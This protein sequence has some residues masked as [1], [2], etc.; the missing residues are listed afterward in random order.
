MQCS[1]HCVQLGFDGVGRRK[2]TA[3][4]GSHRSAERDPEKVSVPEMV[5]GNVFEAHSARDH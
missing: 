4:N 3:T 5:S 2:V 1:N